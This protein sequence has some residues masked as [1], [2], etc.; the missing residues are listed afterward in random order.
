VELGGGET[1]TGWTE[2]T[3]PKMLTSNY[4]DSGRIFA[5][6][7]SGVSIPYTVNWDYIVIPEK[8]IILLLGGAVIVMR[9]IKKR[10]VVNSVL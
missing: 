2:G 5:I 10:K 9:L 7:A 8:V 1:D 4:A 3:Y 6:W